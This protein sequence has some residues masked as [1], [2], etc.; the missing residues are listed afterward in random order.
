MS[1]ASL[2]STTRLIGAWLLAGAWSVQAVTAARGLKRVPSL[3]DPSSPAYPPAATSLVEQDWPNLHVIAV[4]DR[5]SDATG[6][7]MASLAKQSPDRLSVLHVTHLPQGWL[8]KTHAM[9]L[10]ARHARSLFPS[11]WLLFTD[12]D[13]IFHP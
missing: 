11:R 5:S 12:G 6:D 13:V 3:L 7:I 8:G 9:A 10:A 2:V 4:N 1:L